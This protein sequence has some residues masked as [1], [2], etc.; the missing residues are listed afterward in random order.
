MTGSRERQESLP[1][2]FR[3]G[4]CNARRETVFPRNCSEMPILQPCTSSAKLP[5]C[6][7]LRAII[8]V[9]SLRL[10]DLPLQNRPSK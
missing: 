4:E 3:R 8:S 2:V 9:K 1:T 10:C 7:Q 5:Q 6:A